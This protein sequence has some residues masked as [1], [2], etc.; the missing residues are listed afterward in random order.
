MKVEFRAATPDEVAEI[1]MTA[2]EVVLPVQL[3]IAHERWL[4]AIAP[5]PIGQPFAHGAADIRSWQP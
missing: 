3:F 5:F 1:D 2:D 4:E